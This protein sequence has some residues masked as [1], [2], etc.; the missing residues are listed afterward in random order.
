MVAI[1]QVHS[2]L[3]ASVACKAGSRSGRA[4]VRQGPVAGRVERHAPAWVA[5]RTALA[6]Y[7]RP[8]G[9]GTPCRTRCSIN[10]APL[11]RVPPAST[12]RCARCASCWRGR[13]GSAPE[14]TGRS[15]WSRRQ[16]AATV[17]PSMSAMRSCTT[18]PWSRSWRL[19]ARSS[20]RSWTRC[21]PT[22]TWCSPRMVCRNRCRPRRSAATC[23]IST[24]PARWSARCTARRSGTMPRAARTAGT[25]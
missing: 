24:P 5:F 6:I 22:G 11:H 9:R 8:L 25:S 19:R 1:G 17:R 10:Q 23:S 13:A 15:A 3:S 18:A 12:R 14:W 21:R 2:R 7:C 16:S 4:P 20:S